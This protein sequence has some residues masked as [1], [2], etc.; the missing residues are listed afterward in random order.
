EAS[1]L[2]LDNGLST[3]YGTAI[4]QWLSYGGL[5]Q[6]WQFARQP[7]GNWV[8]TNAYSGQVLDD[9]AGSTNNGTPLVHY[10]SNGGANQEWSLYGAGD[11]AAVTDYVFNDYSFKVLDD[12]GGSTYNGSN[13]I[14][15]QFNGGANQ[16]W[17]FVQIDN[18]NYV[19]VNAASGLVLDD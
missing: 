13:I 15:Y 12:P 10:P 14:Q 16:Q 18:G 9:P 5:N 1:Q 17:T 2:V 4:D 6:R 7:D 19:I 3:S 11:A 8:I